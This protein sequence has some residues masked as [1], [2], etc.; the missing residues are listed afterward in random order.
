MSVWSWSLCASFEALILIRDEEMENQLQVHKISFRSPFP[1]VEVLLHAFLP[2][3][4]IDHT[5]AEAI[6]I[7]TSQPDGADI[8]KEALG[9]KAA[10]LPYCGP[11]LA[12]AKGGLREY[13]RNPEMEALVV[14]GHGIFTFG[15]EART[16][17]ERMVAFVAKAEGFIR[18]KTRGRKVGPGRREVSARRKEVSFFARLTQDDPRGGRRPDEG[19]RASTFLYRGA[20]HARADPRFG[21][22]GSGSI[23]APP[24]F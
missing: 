1:S 5:H 8:L 15:E 14:A 21:R 7:L 24:G 9:A 19:R 4:F 17:Y 2:Y 12:L 3:R 13:G 22:P 18:R 23:F 10:F 16:A 6:L 20:Q 11:G